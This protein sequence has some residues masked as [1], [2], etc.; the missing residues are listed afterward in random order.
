MKNERSIRR[1]NEREFLYI[2][3]MKMEKISLVKN[4]ITQRS[5]FF[6][7]FL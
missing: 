3:H 5:K 6:E 1:S 4:N 7:L 2:N